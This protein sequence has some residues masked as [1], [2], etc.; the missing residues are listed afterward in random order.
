ML[1]R[2]YGR[3][4]AP[5]P[6]RPSAPLL[7]RASFS[8]DLAHYT[9]I[10]RLNEGSVAKIELALHT[11]T[12]RHVVLRVQVW[13]WHCICYTHQSSTTLRDQVRRLGRVM[14]YVTEDE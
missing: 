13:N 5:Q 12:Q 11:P 6:H 1:G 7:P 10:E 9:I 3:L 2:M 8:T 4:F 14:Q